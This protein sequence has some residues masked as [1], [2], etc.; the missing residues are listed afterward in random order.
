LIFSCN[1]KY[2]CKGF[3]R[4]HYNTGPNARS[5]N[6]GDL[7]LQ[8]AMNNVRKRDKNTCKWYNCDSKRTI[9]VHHIF[10]VSEYAEL[11]YLEKYMICYCKKHHKEWH[12]KRGDNCHKLLKI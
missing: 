5:W 1:R 6:H 9:Q 10:P 3:C 7:Y 11:K 2:Y 4:K 8:V 12:E